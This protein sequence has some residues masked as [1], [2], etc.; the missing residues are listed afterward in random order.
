M[1]A[2]VAT[3]NKLDLGA[4]QNCREGFESVDIHEDAEHQVDLFSFPWPFEDESVEEIHCSH[5]VEHTPDLVAFMNEMWRI[6]VPGAT[7]T[8]IHPFLKSDR[9]FQDPT[10][11]RFIPD[12]TWWY[13]NE[14]WR[15]AQK[16]D[17]YPIETDFQVANIQSEWI[18]PWNT[19][20]HEAQQFALRHYWN[21][22]TDLVVTLKKPDAA[23]SS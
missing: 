10:H 8:I 18:H 9:A 14:E 6:M 16:L 20:S 7:A 19:R 11:T 21:V 23:S 3:K 15:K 12:V 17:H 2:R 22:V 1:S 5:F 4:G 13:F